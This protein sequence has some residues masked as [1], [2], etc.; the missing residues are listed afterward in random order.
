MPPCFLL[1][2]W[3]ESGKS[4][5]R[6]Q[7]FTLPYLSNPVSPFH[8]EPLHDEGFSF[9]GSML[10]IPPSSCVSTA[11]PTNTKTARWGIPGERLLSVSYFFTI[12]FSFF[13]QLIAR[14]WAASFL[15]ELNATVVSV[16][17]RSLRLCPR[18]FAFL[19]RFPVALQLL[20]RQVYAS[21]PVLRLS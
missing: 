15:P 8:G 20:I 6:D 18:H 2:D 21:I 13:R 4:N 9:G 12:L 11:A 17:H 1:R 3:Y 19:A 14:I 7:T 16:L 5:R 10:C